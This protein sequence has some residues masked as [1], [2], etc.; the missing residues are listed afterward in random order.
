[1]PG[2]TSVPMA[3]IPGDISLGGDRWHSDT[4]YKESQS[5]GNVLII[6]DKMEQNL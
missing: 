6:V 2:G 5:K 1:M 4:A 3:T